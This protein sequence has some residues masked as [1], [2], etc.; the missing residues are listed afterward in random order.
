MTEKA[1][2]DRNLV[3]GLRRGDASAIEALVD[4]YA[5]WI[6]RLARRLL[7]D[8]RDAEEVTQDVLLT[9]VQKI[10]TFRGDAALSSWL[11]RIAANAAYQRLRAR[12]SRA[13]VSLDAFLPVFDDEGRHVQPVVDWSSQLD[14]PAVAKESRAAIERSLSRL[15]EEYRIVILLRDVEGLPN[16]E[17]AAAL[18]LSVAAVKS[19]VHRARLFLRQELAP[20]FSPAR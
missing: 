12:R 3:E 2:E 11:Y 10:Q 19:R 16:E 14:D 1:R 15:P 9:V 8:P 20:L 18:G 4:R 13:E 6:H 17:V 5:G 7:D